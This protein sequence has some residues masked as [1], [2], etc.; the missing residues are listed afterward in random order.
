MAID[1]DTVIRLAR[2]AVNSGDGCELSGDAIERFA[3]LVFL[4]AVPDLTPGEVLMQRAFEA[5]WVQCAIWAERDDL[6]TDC[7]SAAYVR[8]R[9]ATLEKLAP[10]A[11][12]RGKVADFNTDQRQRTRHKLLTKRGRTQESYMQTSRALMREMVRLQREI[13]CDVQ[14]LTS[15]AVARGAADPQGE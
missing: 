13:Q 7:D 10:V 15:A 5:G 2:Q 11:W 1:R 4:E 8:E 3:Q 9:D 14:V 6:I 12:R